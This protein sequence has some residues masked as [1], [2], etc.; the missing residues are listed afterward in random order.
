[1]HQSDGDAIPLGDL[2]PRDA[3]SIHFYKPAVDALFKRCS[4]FA[5]GR[6]VVSVNVD[7]FDREVI[8]VSVAQ[9]P[10]LEDREIAPFIADPDPAA[11]PF[12]VVRPSL[13]EAPSAHVLPDAVDPAF[14]FAMGSIEFPDPLNVGA[15]A[16]G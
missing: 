8:G 16:T 4:P 7:S 2:R 12:W 6:L 3:I 10:F 5:I 13:I 14:P 15:S 9:R 1:M 11:S